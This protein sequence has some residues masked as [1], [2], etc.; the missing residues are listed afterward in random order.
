MKRLLLF[1]GTT[2][3]RELAA[4]AAKL[5]WDVT[6]SVATDYGATFVPEG[7]GVTVHAGRLDEGAMEALM[8]SGFTVAVDATHPYAVAVSANI[9]AAA[10]RAG[11]PLL[12]LLRPESAHPDCLYADSVAEACTLVPAGNVLAATGSKEVAA[13]RAIPDYQA[14]VYAR[15]LPLES[16]IAD[17]HRAG[18]DDGHILAARG[19][20]TL[21][22]NI[23]TMERYAIRSM[24]TKDGGAAGGFP[25]KL[26][27]A[28]RCGVQVILVRR[29]QDSGLPYEEICKRLEAWT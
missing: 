13:Y 18:L 1:G 6:V 10:E 26:E 2:E 27:A 4:A 20:F 28:R 19:P 5:G 11:L 12:R 9:R 15:V 16:S 29:P 8:G 23:D 24:I 21:E 7:D 3:G 17:C 25:E 14:R 22:D